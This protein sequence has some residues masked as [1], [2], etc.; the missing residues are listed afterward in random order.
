M[1]GAV[2]VQ[3]EG[4]TVK[5]TL[6]TEDIIEP[7]AVLR[8][9][10][11]GSDDLTDEIKDAARR[12]VKEML[13]NGQGLLFR[14]TPEQIDSSLRGRALIMPPLG[15]SIIV[16]PNGAKRTFA[17]M[18]ILESSIEIFEEEQPLSRRNIF[19]QRYAKGMRSDAFSA[20]NEYF[21]ALDPVIMSRVIALGRNY[22][23]IFKMRSNPTAIDV[24][25]FHALVAISAAVPSALKYSGITF[26]VTN[27]AIY[28][29]ICERFMS[30]RAADGINWNLRNR[31]RTYALR[32]YQT[33]AVNDLVNSKNNVD[34][35]WLPPGAGKTLIIME[36]F[37]KMSEKT[38][39]TK[40]FIW[41]TVPE[42]ATNLMEQLGDA[43][44]PFN[45]LSFNA[46]GNRTFMENRVNII[47]HDHLAKMDFIESDNI[48]TNSTVIIDEFHKCMGK[49]L[50]SDAAHELT[51]IAV[52]T[53]LMTGT[54]V[55]DLKTPGELVEYLASGVRFPVTT[56]NYTVAL[57][58]VV[59][60]RVPSM[61]L[62]SSDVV[63][64]NE[65]A[66][67]RMAADAKKFVNEKKLG[68]F[69]CV[70]TIEVQ[71]N[72]ANLLSG[73][74]VY[75]IG[76][77]GKPS[78]GP[79]YLPVRDS[80]GEIIPGAVEPNGAPQIVITTKTHV[81]GYEL[82]RY[83][84][85]F[86]LL[87]RSNDATR[88]QA[89]G[90]IDR[91]T[92]IAKKIEYYTYYNTSQASMMEN[93][94]K[95]GDFADTLNDLQSGEGGRKYSADESQQ[96][97][98]EARE[99]AERAKREKERYEKENKSSSAHGTIVEAHIILGLDPKSRPGK[100]EL[101]SAYRKNALKFH[102]DRFMDAGEAIRYEAQEN[103]K[104][105]NNANDL[106]KSHY[107]YY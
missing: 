3:V 53:I 88:R 80:K 45:L 21:Q 67:E 15:G 82:N 32:P 59:T 74:N 39:A 33:K 93:Y 63:E 95:I 22:S 18:P 43:N 68:V 90:R 29:D 64:C 2:E 23:H 56:H 47:L 92:N 61:S 89:F 78:W 48:L 98:K 52:R 58:K 44:L 77:D 81:A 86:M 102:P 91:Q 75:R 97:A 6:N 69:I 14:H 101:S 72:V 96:Y 5:V 85:M 76:I 12:E 36:Y 51:K 71:V 87:F 55:R 34:I 99:R 28:W 26:T 83:I 104:K 84:I 38:A 24:A 54:I 7:G 27:G 73:L 70:D 42:A 8:S 37:R 66:I 41:T 62:I 9:A 11:H 13:V 31:V 100:S 35:V 107:G 106:L 25:A 20:I 16:E 57:G 1:I 10:E 17:G 4:R 94:T 40:Y 105:I 60:E 49:S 46:G 65:N 79:D 30:M 50:R 103:M 19:K